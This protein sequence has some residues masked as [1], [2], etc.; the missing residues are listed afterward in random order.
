M[1][2]YFISKEAAK[3]L[4][5]TTIPA[6]QKLASTDVITTEA[7]AYKNIDRVNTPLTDQQLALLN[8]NGFAAQKQINEKNA[9]LGKDYEKVRSL[10]KK[11]VHRGYTGRGVKV[12]VLDT[13]CGGI[14]PYDFGVN[15][16]GV[17]GVGDGAIGHGTA[18]AG[19]IKSSQ[20]GLA[21]GCELHFLKVFN[22]D[23]IIDVA[24]VVAALDYCVD[25]NIH[26]LNM[27]FRI[28]TSNPGDSFRLGIAAYVA[29]GGIPFAS[30]GNDTINSLVC[31]PAALPGVVAV[32]AVNEAGQAVYK[33][34]IVPAFDGAHGID[35]ACSGIGC[36]W[37][38]V[39]GIVSPSNG[40]SYS[41]PWN[42]GA[43]AIYIEMLGWPAPAVALQRMKDKAL[44]QADSANLNRIPT[45]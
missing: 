24:A 45:F 9:A 8:S 3:F 40:T 22:D 29:S 28:D 6:M 7:L 30:S 1:T 19:I 41:S 43:L 17:T 32:N 14:V 34:N 42:A 15:F 44:K 36:E 18:V 5:L 37:L 27:S 10:Y 33:N 12:A 23:E 21:N 13:G 2:R 16:A 4:G 31:I 26:I 25:N 39:S 11:A 38:D 35:F 20:I